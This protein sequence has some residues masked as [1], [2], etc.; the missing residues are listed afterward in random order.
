MLSGCNSPV[1]LKMV[2]V[3]WRMQT[4]WLGVTKDGHVRVDLPPL[5]TQG[6][7]GIILLVARA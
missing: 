2:S 5:E 1:H 3:A 7:T 4:I 6:L